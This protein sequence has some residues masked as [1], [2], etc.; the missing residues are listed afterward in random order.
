MGIRFLCPTCG[1]KLNVKS[2][3]A[4]KRGVCPQ[5]GNGL[6]IP[7][8]S[9]VEKDAHGGRPVGVAVESPPVNLDAPM[10]AAAAAGP[11]TI[12]RTAPQPA[13]NAAVKPAGREA[14][15]KPAARNA[16]V[17]QVDR[18]AES[19]RSDSGPLAVPMQPVQVAQPA[20]V[21]VVTPVEPVVAQPLPADPIDEAPEAIWYVRP[22]T[23][24]QYGP[25]RGEIMR[26]WMGEG[27]VSPDSLVWREGWNDWCTAADVFPALGVGTP[28]VSA[29]VPPGS[30]AGAPLPASS[31]RSVQRPRRRNSALLA[32]TVVSVLG[33]MC[34]AL[35]VALIL[36]LMR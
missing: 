13:E 20:A 9:Q 21:P 10:K 35:F 2:F 31:S 7:Y 33:L 32:V 29:P 3:L 18:P 23:G 14:V 11:L 16:S 30:L 24:G 22:P 1:N 12:P 8:E 26:K 15:K 28:P 19:R 34:I 4:G 27:R 36:I 6:D 5:C 25:A 17:V